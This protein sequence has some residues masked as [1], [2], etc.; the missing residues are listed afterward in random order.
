M[1]PMKTAMK[2]AL[3]GMRNNHGG[4]FG[5][6]VTKD[7]KII[8][9]AHNE[10]IKRNDPTAHAEVLAIRNAAKKLNKFDLSDC[11]LYTTCEPCPMCIAAIH[12]A[13]IRKIH[14]GC[15]RQDAENIGFKDNEIYE[16]IKKDEKNTETTQEDREECMK[17]FKEWEAK[18]NKIQY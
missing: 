16:I 4:P 5:A 14:Y 9:K 2:E 11:E 3:K 1:K 6:V 7:G 8:A 18:E 13:K 15:T 12:W 17:A 10:V